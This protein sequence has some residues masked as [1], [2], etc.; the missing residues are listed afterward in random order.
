MP[1]LDPNKPR[2]RETVLAAVQ[3]RIDEITHLAAIHDR[4][5][6][7]QRERELYDDLLQTIADKQIPATYGPVIARIVIDGV[8]RAW[9]NTAT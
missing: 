9:E 7:E 2:T 8:Q 3:T 6:A 4:D 5:L 1:L